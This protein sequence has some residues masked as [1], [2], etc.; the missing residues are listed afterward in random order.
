MPDVASL[1]LHISRHYGVRSTARPARGMGD[2]Q[3]QVSWLAAQALPRSPSQRPDEVASGI[4]TRKLTAYSCGRSRG[5]DKSTFYRVP[6]SVAKNTF[7][8]LTGLLSMTNDTRRM[9]ARVMGFIC[10][11][12]GGRPRAGRRGRCPWARCQY[13]A[14]PRR[15]RLQYR[16]HAVSRR[17]KTAYG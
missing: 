17:G 15:S 14:G 16:F 12:V 6:L 13:P 2:T 4:L 3:R 10:H 1:R 7:G 9:N 8:H 5:V 11:N